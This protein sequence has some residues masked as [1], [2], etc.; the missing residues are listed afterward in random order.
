MQANDTYD[1]TL[2]N[3]RKGQEAFSRLVYLIYLQMAQISY[4][5]LLLAFAQHKAF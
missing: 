4:V 1:R 3:Q 2:A 5:N